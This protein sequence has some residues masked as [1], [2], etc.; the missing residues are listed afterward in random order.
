ME[1]DGEFD[2]LPGWSH[3]RGGG[4]L[5]GWGPR[6]G[7]RD[8]GTGGMVPGGEEGHWEERYERPLWEG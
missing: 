8:R 3:N 6:R 4:G 1:T 5:A 2:L 7:E